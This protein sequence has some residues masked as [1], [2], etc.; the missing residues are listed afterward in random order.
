MEVLEIENDG[1]S[2]ADLQE[3]DEDVL[4]EITVWIQSCK[5]LR[6]LTLTGVRDSLT[7]L[8][9]VLMT[10]GIRLTSLDVKFLRQFDPRESHATWDA[11]KLQHK[12]ESF[13]LGA[14]LDQQEL[15]ILAEYPNLVDAICSLNKLKSLNLKQTFAQAREIERLIA[16]LPHL[17]D[18]GFGGELVTDTILEPLA[19]LPNLA[20]VSISAQSEFTVAGLRRF[21]RA[22]ESRGRP[23]FQCEILGQV[24]HLKL[25]QRD[26]RELQNFFA[27]RLYGRF[28]IGYHMDPDELHEDDFSDLS[29]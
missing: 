19:A 7:I 9:D 24:G 10:P 3:F 1:S 15:F 8:K 11:L 25:S 28:D 20:T 13:T 18:F 27:D 16:S 17:I 5:S 26:R 22:I 23:G 6:D 21:A 29:D 12:L 4:K 2:Q 14:N